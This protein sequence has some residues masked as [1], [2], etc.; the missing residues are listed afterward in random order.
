MHGE[1]LT[2]SVVYTPEA[3]F[4][5]VDSFTYTVSDGTND[6]PAATVSITVDPVNDAPVAESDS[7][8]P[9]RT[10]RWRWIRGRSCPTS[11]H[12]TRT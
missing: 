8:T 1:P 7:L 2:A 9:P 12:S 3:N 6:S 10:P 11:R 4:N 5:G